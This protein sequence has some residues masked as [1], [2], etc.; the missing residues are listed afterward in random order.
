MQDAVKKMLLTVK[1]V[2]KLQ[3]EDFLKESALKLLQL[4]LLQVLNLLKLQKKP[5]EKLTNL[6]EKKVLVVTGSVKVV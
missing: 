4:I 6:T 1:T 3:K 5:V 2:E